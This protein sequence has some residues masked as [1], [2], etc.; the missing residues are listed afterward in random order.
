MPDPVETPQEIWNACA[1][2][3]DTVFEVHD[4]V[5]WQRDRRLDG[6]A[7]WRMTAP[8]ADGMS[9]TLLALRFYALSNEAAVTTGR[10]LTGDDLAG[11]PLAGVVSE[12]RRDYE[13]FVGFNA[14]APD[15][16][17]SHWMNIL[18]LLTYEQRG[19]ALTL[20]RLDAVI[21]ETVDR[22]SARYRNPELTVRDLNYRSPY[23]D[24]EPL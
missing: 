3:G 5:S 23:A 20:A 10:P 13:L 17:R 7:V 18:K 1:A 19:S 12:P 6:Y 8:A 21:R 9:R 11:V 15:A 22:L 14:V 16:A 4:Q 24:Y 2:Y